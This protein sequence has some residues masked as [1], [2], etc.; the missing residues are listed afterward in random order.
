ME[1]D[2]NR[3]TPDHFHEKII[4]FYDGNEYEDENHKTHK[5]NGIGQ[6][7]TI[8]NIKKKEKYSKLN[9]KISEKKWGK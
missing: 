9:W 4:H 8:F 3:K 7:L 5:S 1:Y 2:H 6:Y